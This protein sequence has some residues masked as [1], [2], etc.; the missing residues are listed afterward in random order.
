MNITCDCGTT[1]E[2]T[3]DICYDQ[4]CKQYRATCQVCEQ[5]FFIT[6]TPFIKDIGYNK[7]ELK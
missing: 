2:I 3:L 7:E 6:I 1:T 5:Y 4:T